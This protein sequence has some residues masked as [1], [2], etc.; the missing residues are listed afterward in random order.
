[1]PDAAEAAVEE[2]L[3]ELQAARA[4]AVTP[5]MAAAA[6][7]FKKPLREILFIAGFLSSFLRVFFICLPMLLRSVQR[8]PVQTSFDNNLTQSFAPVF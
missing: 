6:A 1:M 3:A 4:P 5:D 2:E 8:V 7:I